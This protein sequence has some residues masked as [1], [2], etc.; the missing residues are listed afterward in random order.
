MLTLLLHS[1]LCRSLSPHHRLSCSPNDLPCVWLHTQLAKW[2][3]PHQLLSAGRW[4]PPAIHFW[5]GLS[6]FSPC[7]EHRSGTA[8]DNGSWKGTASSASKWINR[9]ACATITAQTAELITL[10]IA[11]LS[12]IPVTLSP[13]RK[14]KKRQKKKKS[15]LVLSAH[16]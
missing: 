11:R 5:F 14:R 3:N 1:N 4:I 13:R 10:S 16:N 8:L 2:T 12:H 15:V 7:E 9:C 6:V